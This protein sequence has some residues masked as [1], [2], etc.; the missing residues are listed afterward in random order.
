MKT[1]KKKK[2]NQAIGKVVLA[3]SIFV[4]LF[5]GL[6]RLL[7]VYQVVYVGAMFEILWLPVILLLFI[8]PILSII[9]WIQERFNP[10]SIYLY[11]M[12]LGIAAVVLMVYGK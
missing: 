5:V 8:L 2:T 1:I 6:S 11:S 12:I 3:L 10:K 9:N 7:N 4:L